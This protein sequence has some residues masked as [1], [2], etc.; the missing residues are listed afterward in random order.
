MRG[1]AVRIV[2]CGVKETLID[3]YLGAYILVQVVIE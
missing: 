3:I 2:L 1:I